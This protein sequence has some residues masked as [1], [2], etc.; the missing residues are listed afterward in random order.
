ME[1]F[2]L[3]ICK[4]VCVAQFICKTIHQGPGT[5][6]LPSNIKIIDIGTSESNWKE[7]KHAQCGQRSRLQSD[8]SEKQ[9]MLYDAANMHKS[10]IMG[11][12]CLYKWTNMM[13]DMGLDNIVHNYRELLHFRISNAWINNWESYI[14]RTLDRENEKRIL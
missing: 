10:S 5:G 11:T 14:L 3:K 1:K 9:A 12:R 2:F 6:W 7:Y 8:S 4:I 13:S